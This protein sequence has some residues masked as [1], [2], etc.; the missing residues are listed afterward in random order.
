M[1]V[2]PYLNFA[3]NAEEALNFYKSVFGGE[4]AMIMRMKDAPNAD[5]IPESE[6]NMIMHIALPLGKDNM[7]MAS[8]APESMGFKVTH[9]NGT[10]ISLSPDSREETKRIF[11]A[12]SAGG[13]VEV[14]LQD[15]FW[16]DY[17]GSFTDKFGIG[18]MLN[19]STQR[20]QQ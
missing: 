19:F 20:Y 17:F 9:G 12:L 2:N 4:F 1:K 13:K 10:Y 14:N 11:D 15:Q 5:K 6:K 18:W 7:L 3:G 16:G 8:D